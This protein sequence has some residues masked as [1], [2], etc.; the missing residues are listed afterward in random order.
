MLISLRFS[1]MHS[2]QV[3]KPNVAKNPFD[4]AFDDD[5]DDGDDNEAAWIEKLSETFFDLKKII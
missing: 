4:S 1:A 3:L 2:M 5:D